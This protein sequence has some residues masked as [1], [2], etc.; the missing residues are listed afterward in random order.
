MSV[1]LYRS[2]IE[3]RDGRPLVVG[4]ARGLGPRPGEI[5]CD[6][7]GIVE[8]E[9]GG[10]SVALDDP[11]HLVPHRRPEE[12]GGTGSDPLWVMDEADLGPLLEC[13]RDPKRPTEH[14]F[15][16]PVRPMQLEEYEL[17][18]AETR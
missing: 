3:D 4:T 1:L 17:A 10:I 18:L 14:G 12:F 8:P 15:L 2:M 7:D 11:A 6:E 5:G 13:R 9:A 16:E